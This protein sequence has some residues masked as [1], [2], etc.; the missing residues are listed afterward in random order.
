MALR[1]Q[2]SG[3]GVMTRRVRLIVVAVVAVLAVFTI[4][5]LATVGGVSGESYEWNHP[6]GYFVDMTIDDAQANGASEAQVAILEDSKRYESVT[7]YQIEEA[8]RAAVACMTA[9]GIDAEYV[10][11]LSDEAGRVP[12]IRVT[13]GSP[14]SGVQDG[15]AAC[16]FQE[17]YWVRGVYFN[18]LWDVYS[19]ETSSTRSAPYL[20]GCLAEHGVTADSAMTGMELFSLASEL[21]QDPNDP[22]DCDQE[23]NTN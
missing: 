19:D 17:F 22:V 9:R 10:K 23:S 16:Y 3:G 7:S 13:G 12:G 4:A 8:G 15:F 21:R 1:D 20:I 11:D 6:Y 5:F 14:D 2:R 18:D